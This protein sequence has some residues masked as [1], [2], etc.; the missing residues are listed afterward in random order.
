MNLFSR[1]L[2]CLAI[3]SI[4]SCGEKEPD[5]IDITPSFTNTS[6]IFVDCRPSF[7]VTDFS[8]EDEDM[9]RTHLQDHGFIYSTTNVN[10]IEDESS[11]IIS[12]GTDLILNQFVV[13]SE[14]L[15]TNT[16]YYARAFL[17]IYDQYF[18]SDEIIFTT[19]PGTWNKLGDFPGDGLMNATGFSIN[20]KGYIV[21]KNPNQFYSEVW[22]YDPEFDSWVQKNEAPFSSSGPSSFVINNVGYVYCNALWR[23]DQSMDTWIHNGYGPANEFTPEEYSKGCRGVSS[24]VIDNKAYIGCG[25]GNTNEG[26]MEFNALNNEWQLLDLNQGI[27]PNRSYSTSFVLNDMAYIVG[28]DMSFYEND[29]SIIEYDLQN[30]TS[31]YKG[32]FKGESSLGLDRK[33]MIS[34]VINDEAFL[35]M[36]YGEFANEFGIRVGSQSDFYKYE[37][38][39]NWW[40]RQNNPTQADE[41]GIINCVERAGGVSIVVNGRAFMGLGVNRPNENSS[42]N[43]ETIIYKDFWEFIPN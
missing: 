27:N 34:F 4:F 38:D 41:N 16:T 9:F 19:R 7:L 33:E 39:I 32:I 8:V 18:Y 12:K 35:G 26:F 1:F 17:K 42:E 31:V 11:I 28:G 21:G 40:T 43:T 37:P 10:S 25:V 36:G 5:I 24:F 6:F 20:N 30:M 29:E 14:N 2:L 15:L 23:Y 3:F 13:T 22:E